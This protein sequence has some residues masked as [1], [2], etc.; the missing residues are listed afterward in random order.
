MDA[1]VV[2]GQI[3]LRRDSLADD[4]TSL[5]DS[6][7]LRVEKHAAA[8]SPVSQVP[9]VAEVV[10][11]ANNPTPTPA[12]TQLEK[13]EQVADPGLAPKAP[14]VHEQPK[15]PILGQPKHPLQRKKTIPGMWIDSDDE[16]EEETGWA[17]VVSHTK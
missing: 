12:P 7:T 6:V 1:D 10:E 11:S 2:D 14:P 3:W 16:D 15:A 8:E 17:S 5:L 13:H 4:T 9:R